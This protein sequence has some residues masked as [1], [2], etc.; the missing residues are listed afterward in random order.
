MAAVFRELGREFR[1]DPRVI[2]YF[3]GT[4]KLLSV[5]DFEY[6]FATAADVESIVKDVPE[7]IIPLQVSR[8]R[9]AWEGVKC[10]RATADLLKRK[11]IETD[12]MD[13]MLPQ[14]QLENFGDQFWLR[15]HVRFPPKV[16]PSE[17][18]ISKCA[19]KLEKR[20]LAV[21]DVWSTRTLAHQ[22]KAERKRT[23]LTNA[24]ALSRMI[25]K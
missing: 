24:S 9:Q 7:I 3:T 20:L 11:G 15:Y 25:R 5:A 14:Q 10:V 21:D 2:N 16:E 13:T 18:L 22:S 1:I 6:L 17:Y 19:K 12:D 8:V 4:L 23:K